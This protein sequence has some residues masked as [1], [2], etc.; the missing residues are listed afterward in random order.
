MIFNCFP[1]SCDGHVIYFAL[2]NTQTLLVQ[3]EQCYYCLFGH[4]QKKAKARGLSDHKSSQVRTVMIE[5]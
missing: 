5:L 2:Y 4:P 3:L 1:R